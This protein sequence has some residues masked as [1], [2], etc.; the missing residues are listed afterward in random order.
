M[1]ASPR[2][3][4][5]LALHC[6]KCGLCSPASSSGWKI[7]QVS[8]CS[9]QK[10]ANICKFGL[11][12]GLDG[13]REIRHKFDTNSTPNSI[14]NLAQKVPYF[15]QKKETRHLKFDTNSTQIRKDGTDGRACGRCARG[16]KDSSGGR[17]TRGLPE[18]KRQRYGG[19]ERTRGPQR[20]REAEGQEA[21][22]PRARGGQ[23]GR[24][25]CHCLQ[26]ACASSITR[27]THSLVRTFWFASFARARARRLLERA[28][29]RR[30]CVPCGTRRTR[31][32]SR[33]TLRPRSSRRSQ[34]LDAG[35]KA[36]ACR[37]IPCWTWRH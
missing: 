5:S 24:Q 13:P 30:Q 20:E 7:D 28:W 32:A 34:G 18:G 3:T 25:G 8:G 16:G 14:S 9:Q 29:R 35:L 11:R 37:R 2:C 6:Q 22:G 33:Q 1:E 36:G 21:E 12:G 26:S 19:T 15:P 17:T 10:R 23:R 4:P 27:H 31:G